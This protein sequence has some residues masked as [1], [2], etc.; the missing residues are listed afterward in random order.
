MCIGNITE[1]ELFT[2][3]TTKDNYSP[4]SV[5]RGASSLALT[6]EVNLVTES[7]A[8]SEAQ[9]RESVWEF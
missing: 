6:R 5:I 2:G 9:I 3:D 1:S 8:H 4:G 7:S